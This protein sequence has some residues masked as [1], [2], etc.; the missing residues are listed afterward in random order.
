MVAVV[1]S[2][3]VIFAAFLLVTV[4]CCLAWVVLE[5]RWLTLDRKTRFLRSLAR[6]T[7]RAKGNRA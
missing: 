3:L 7:S 5:R 6:M 1:V 2:G 4:A